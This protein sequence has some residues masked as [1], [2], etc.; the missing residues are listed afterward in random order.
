MPRPGSAKKKPPPLPAPPLQ[1]WV[2]DVMAEAACLTKDIWPTP[3]TPKQHC[4]R[5]GGGGF[6]VGA[7]FSLAQEGAQ[8]AL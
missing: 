1:S 8:S 5:G 3:P 6:H 2:Q 4:I 7:F